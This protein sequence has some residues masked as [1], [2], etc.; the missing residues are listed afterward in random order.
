V[1]VAAA[2]GGNDANTILLAHMDGADGGTVFT[3][4]SQ[5]ARVLTPQFSFTTSTVK[6]QFGG[7]S[8]FSLFSSDR[9]TSPN[10]A[11]LRWAVTDPF[12]IDCWVNAVSNSW[13]FLNMGWVFRFQG[14]TKKVQFI[15]TSGGAHINI[16]SAGSV[17]VTTWTHIAVSKSAA[18]TAYVYINGVVDGT[19]TQTSDI[20]DS[21]TLLQ[22]GSI[23]AGQGSYI[24]EVRISNIDRYG[25]V[26]FTPPTA[27][28]F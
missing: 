3:D 16:I 22:V 4:S 18:G 1:P 5:V 28:Y 25:G 13:A 10:T 24:D 12:T 23:S 9:V 7:A 27:A 21:T 11:D 19:A 17:P 26:N 8:G 14:G 2:S 6:S 15:G 20:T